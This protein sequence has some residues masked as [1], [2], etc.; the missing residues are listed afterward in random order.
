M[1]YCSCFEVLSGTSR[2]TE[3]LLGTPCFVEA[4]DS[5]EANVASMLLLQICFAVLLFVCTIRGAF[6]LLM[7]SFHSSFCNSEVFFKA[8]LLVSTATLLLKFTGCAHPTPAMADAMEGNSLDL[9]ATAA[10]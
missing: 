8:F 3:L 6:D 1:I 5:I 9:C 2:A 7:I 4:F 10:R